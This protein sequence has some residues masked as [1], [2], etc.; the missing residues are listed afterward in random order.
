MRIT[1]ALGIYQEKSTESQTT[2]QGLSA[3]TVNQSQSNSANLCPRDCITPLELRYHLRI[4][5]YWYSV[6]IF[7]YFGVYL[8]IIDV[9]TALHPEE[10]SLESKRQL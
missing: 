10:G 4:V 6:L 9:H 7:D 3:V 8:Y 1:S 5:H 2:I